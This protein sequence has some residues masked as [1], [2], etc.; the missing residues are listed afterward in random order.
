MHG[1]EAI[2]WNVA[3]NLALLLVLAVL[4]AAG[5]AFVVEFLQHERWREAAGRLDLKLSGR[6]KDK[7]IF[8][9]VDEFHVRIRQAVRPWRH[10]IEVSGFGEIPAALSIRPESAIDETLEG[11]DFQTGCP[12]FDRQVRIRGNPGEIL[13]VLDAETRRQILSAVVESGARIRT[14]HLTLVQGNIR[15]APET[16]RRLVELGRRLAIRPE[17]VPPR[18]A[19][20]AAE[21]PEPA[22][23]LN[24]LQILQEFHPECAE[25]R[26]ASRIALGSNR[27]EIRLAAARFLGVEG[28]PVA[29]ELALSANAAADIRRQAL[30]HFLRNVMPEDLAPVLEELAAS[31]APELLPALVE[32]VGRVRHAAVLS[33]LTGLVDRFDD[34][35]AAGYA[36]AAVRLGEAA[37][38]PGLLRLLERDAEA[39]QAAAARALAR[40]G[41]VRAVEPLLRLARGSS[42]AP[43]EAARVA[44]L[45]IQSRLGDAE[46]GR[47]SL[48][49]PAEGEGA[50]SLPGE[51][52]PGGELSLPGREST[53]T[54]SDPST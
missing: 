27:P 20:N 14:G 24:N 45:Q 52:R 35:T 54:E 3:G 1:A 42:G 19:R 15:R 22:V 30:E 33:R 39:V 2:G 12:E 6:K 53:P 10:R 34:E 28:L 47:L 40:V 17:E 38:E 18:L 7:E 4:A 43:R 26:E 13:A 29:R 8:G 16:V 36:R 23:R 37:A 32:G 9:L 48:A 50:L 21:D 46:A 5:A 41:T 44:V 11:A 51:E 49:A 25:V 31:P